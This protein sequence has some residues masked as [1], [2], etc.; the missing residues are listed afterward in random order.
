MP[1]SKNE[2]PT[3]KV[4][5]DIAYKGLKAFRKGELVVVEK[6]S[7]DPDRPDFKYV[8]HSKGVGKIMRLS[9]SELELLDSAESPAREQGNRCRKCG[10]ELGPTDAVCGNC[11]YANAPR[12][13]VLAERNNISPGECDHYYRKC[14]HHG[15][16]VA[17]WIR[18]YSSAVWRSQK[19]LGKTRFTS[20]SRCCD[21]CGVEL[22]GGKYCTKCG[23]RVSTA[24]VEKRAAAIERR[25]LLRDASPMERDD[26]RQRSTSTTKL[27]V[28]L[29]CFA[30]TSIFMIVMLV[31]LFSYLAANEIKHRDY[32]QTITSDDIDF[33]EDHEHDWRG[34]LIFL[35]LGLGSGITG[36][37][38]YV[39]HTRD[40]DT[41][42]EKGR[43]KRCPYCSEVVKEQALVCKHCGRDLVGGTDSPR[44]EQAEEKEVQPIK[45][46]E[47]SDQVEKGEVQPSKQTEDTRTCPYC[48]ET[49][50]AAAIKCKHCGSDLTQPPPSSPF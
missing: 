14:F 33:M 9:D 10:G 50:K 47:E 6:V 32:S 48:A 27:S 49:I 38:L 4:L 40:R 13:K 26:L 21:V 19:A 22:S 1:G 45:Q 25:S 42:V 20:D 24:Q 28:S 41:F 46:I 43:T 16:S 3:H 8:V 17:G 12:V 5:R 29:V 15:K 35:F 30:L 36:T 34:L 7:P 23:A 39:S 44:T 11:G 37:V 31:Y 2:S 18:V